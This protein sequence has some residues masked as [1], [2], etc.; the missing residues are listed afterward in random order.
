MRIAL[1]V[2]PIF[3][4]SHPPVGVV[5]LK[6]YLQ[7]FGHTIHCIDLNTDEYCLRL[8][9][10][11]LPT[12]DDPDVLISAFGL[13]MADDLDA[14]L[15]RSHPVI[16][17]GAQRRRKRAPRLDELAEMVSSVKAMLDQ[18]AVE[19]KDAGYE[20]VGCTSFRSTNAC[21]VY[22]LKEVKRRAPHTVTVLGGPTATAEAETIQACCPH[23]D[24]IVAGHG[25]VPFRELLES[26]CASQERTIR[27]RKADVRAEGINTYPFLDYSDFDLELYFDRE[28]GLTVQNGCVFACRFCE[29]QSHFGFPDIR[30]A[31]RTY[32]EMRWLNARHG[33][34]RF[35]LCSAQIN[36]VATQLAQLIAVDDQPL[37][38]YGPASIDPRFSAD[39][40]AVFK[41]GGLCG[42]RFG[43][44]SG[45]DAVLALMRKG[46][47]TRQV[48]P[49]ITT[50]DALGIPTYVMV[51]AG[52]PGETEADH[53]QT[54]ELM[55]RV[56]VKTQ[57]ARA[58][59]FPFFLNPHGNG[60][61]GWFEQHFGPVVRLP[62]LADPV[63][64]YEYEWVLGGLADHR[65]LIE[66]RHQDH[67]RIM[68]AGRGA[69]AD[70]RAPVVAAPMLSESR[71][72]AGL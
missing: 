70:D 2:P 62:L 33:I 37:S 16:V 50:L 64:S 10:Y 28:L 30:T 19:L 21:A 22:L 67:L 72:R 13:L 34:S 1:V 20:V 11:G 4:P 47:R 14:A 9:K 24:F 38:W 66:Q 25:E 53:R 5:A 61:L 60:G 40:A 63:F 69:T 35:H 26:G 39:G 36:H 32:E 65:R 3:Y 8:L 57:L 44:E 31:E 71:R 42:P 51:I 45:S 27:S 29:W 18:C 15:K 41:P 43:V 17:A 56:Y 46:H 55:E 6:S 52:F 59:S 54:C 49:N 48:I 68:M 23:V 7:E 58:V 12:C